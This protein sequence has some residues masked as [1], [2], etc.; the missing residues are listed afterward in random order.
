M[1]GVLDPSRPAVRRGCLRACTKGLHEIVKRFPMASFHKE[2]QRFAVGTV[3]AALTIYDLRTATKWRVL[4]GHSAAVVAASFGPT[5]SVLVSYSAEEG[6]GCGC[7]RSWDAGNSGFFGGLLGLEGR[8]LKEIKLQRVAR[9]RTA[10]SD[11]LKQCGIAWI[12]K[13]ELCLSREDGS[14]ITLKI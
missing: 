12:G 13:R 6:S 1:I 9:A 5:G 3:D 7:L 4:E 10:T 14:Q 2:T 11:V 8:C